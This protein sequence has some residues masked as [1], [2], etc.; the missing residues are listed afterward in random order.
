MRYAG[1]A[2]AAVTAVAAVCVCELRDYQTYS[3]G[4]SKTVKS[5][6]LGQHTNHKLCSFGT[7]HASKA[8]VK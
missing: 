7:E 2:V 5:F 3:D 6:H 8:N 4:T 1:F